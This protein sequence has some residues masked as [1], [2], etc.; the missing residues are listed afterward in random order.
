MSFRLPLCYL[1]VLF[2]AF[3]CQTD[4][5]ISDSVNE[6]FGWHNGDLQ[7]NS[8][9][10]IFRFYIP[11]ALPD[12]SSVVILLHGGTMSMNELF[13]KNS[14]GSRARANAP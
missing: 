4:K 3:A 6:Q 8:Q 10:R 1:I 7:V 13:R 11:K 12:Q 2:T 14:G 9:R 5:A